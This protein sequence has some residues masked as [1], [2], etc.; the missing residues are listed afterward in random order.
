MTLE[1]RQRWVEIAFNVPRVPGEGVT[2]WLLRAICYK[3]VVTMREAKEL[4]GAYIVNHLRIM[5]AISEG[6]EV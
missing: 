2:E 3:G 1:Q 6:I 5:A 4:Y